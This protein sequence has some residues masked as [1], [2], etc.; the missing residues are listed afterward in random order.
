MGASYNVRHICPHSAALFYRCLPRE[1]L[2]TGQEDWMSSP[3]G[4]GL[5]GGL[6]V[7]YSYKEKPINDSGCAGMK[8]ADQLLLGH[9][10]ET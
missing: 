1:T 4:T 7:K 9:R 8:D 6:I 3:C 2:G 5:E 10:V